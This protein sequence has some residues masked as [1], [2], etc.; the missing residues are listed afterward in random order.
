M[1]AMEQARCEFA[2]ASR[3]SGW[4]ALLT[5]TCAVQLG[6]CAP[7]SGSIAPTSLDP[8][9]PGLPTAPGTA[10]PLAGEASLVLRVHPCAAPPGR[11]GTF[12][13][14]TQVDRKTEADIAAVDVVPYV[15]VTGGRFKPIAAATGLPVE[16]GDT[17]LLSARIAPPLASRTV[18]LG[19][20][21]PDTAYRIVSRAYD[22]SGTLI[23]VDEGSRV[24]LAVGQD[25][26]PAFSALLPVQLS[27]TA[28]G[29]SCS[30]TVSVI[31]M[32]GRFDHVRAI[33]YRVGASGSETAVAGGEVMIPASY[34]PRAVEL[35][36]L[37]AETTY[38]VK[39][40]AETAADGSLAQNQ[41]DVVVG[42]DDEPLD[43][44]VVVTLPLL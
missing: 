42:T 28:F 25:D 16:E 26:R 31:G 11:A 21:K 6:A 8:L 2:A 12:R 35:G 3:A 34:L 18:T 29:A 15:Q 32:N 1:C 23:S 24:D 27:D 38:R 30:V 4:T 44:A 20:L 7:S 36:S 33:L 43:L 22:A 40:V 10:S 19:R 5:V 14:Q 9:V 39:A 41:V 13:L 37:Q 17:R